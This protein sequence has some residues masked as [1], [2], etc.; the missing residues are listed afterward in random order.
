M[1]EQETAFD[2]MAV[3]SDSC[4]PALFAASA[5]SS[6][7]HGEMQAWRPAPEGRKPW[8]VGEACNRDE[9]GCAAAG[10]S[11]CDAAHAR[12]RGGLRAERLLLGRSA[13]A[14][15]LHVLAESLLVEPENAVIRRT[16]L[17]EM[18]RVVYLAE[19]SRGVAAHRE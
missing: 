6:R 17:L 4:R 18:P 2:L 10:S 11:R 7:S 14:Q 1:V 3:I 8:S 15:E 13:D 9:D 12:A 19:Q 5:H 16:Q